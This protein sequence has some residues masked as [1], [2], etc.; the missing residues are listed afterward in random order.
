MYDFFSNTF[1]AIF[2]QE[3]ITLVLSIIGAISAVYTFIT[4]IYWN[5]ASVHA[6][7]VSRFIFDNYL[8]LYV[9]FVNL[10]RLPISITSVSVIIDDVF[11]CAEQS[12]VLIGIKGIRKGEIKD[13]VIPRYSMA[14]PIN[15]PSL[16]GSS[17]YLHFRFPRK[18]LESS[19]TELRVSLATNRKCS[20][21]M[22]LQLPEQG[23]I[24]SL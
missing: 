24:L 12:P 20:L 16:A 11:Y 22:T 5:R 23:D 2:T 3:N 4:N 15:L 10:S 9:S 7:I 19:A 18:I 17:G 8:T 13:F 1:T 21:Q 6:T 14:F